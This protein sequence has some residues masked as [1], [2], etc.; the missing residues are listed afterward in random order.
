M[1]DLTILAREPLSERKRLQPDERM[2]PSRAL[3]RSLLPRSAA[4]GLA[5]ALVELGV[6]RWFFTVSGDPARL[7]VWG[8]T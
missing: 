3:L 6:I 8:W 4:A 7:A 2:P 1:T 5:S